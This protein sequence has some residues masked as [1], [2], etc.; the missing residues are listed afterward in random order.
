M[1]N[2]LTKGEDYCVWCNEKITSFRDALSYKEWKISGLCQKCQ[3]KTFGKRK[4]G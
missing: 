3:D 2:V 1:K 4:D